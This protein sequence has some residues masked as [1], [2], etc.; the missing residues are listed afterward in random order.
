MSN[1]KVYVP[2]A[3][4]PICWYHVQ[5][6]SQKKVLS[7][8]LCPKGTQTPLNWT[9]Y[10][11]CWQYTS[12]TNMCNSENV[13]STTLCPKVTQTPPTWQ[14]STHVGSIYPTQI[15]FLEDVR[16]ESWIW[17]MIMQGLHSFSF[18]LVLSFHPKCHFW[19]HSIAFC[20]SNDWTFGK[21]ISNKPFVAS[22]FL[23]GFSTIIAR[24][25]V[26][27]FSRGPV[28]AYPSQVQI[29]KNHKLEWKR[30]KC[31]SLLLLRYRYNTKSL[32]KAESSL[33]LFS[34][35]DL[36]SASPQG[37]VATRTPVKP[38]KFWVNSFVRCEEEH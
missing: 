34:W 38:Q 11:I 13:H 22:P 26:S 12:N 28:A 3:H 24:T 37:A 18:L 4:T 29:Q 2:L 30:Q 7:P 1:T 21:K 14:H 17:S 27:N 23:G 20:K 33:H 5:Y 31:I 6:K 35:W 9:T 8:T 10:P 32:F 15:H 19:E 25:R 16:T 36:V